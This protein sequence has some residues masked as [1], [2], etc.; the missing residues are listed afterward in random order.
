MMKILLVNKYF[1]PR[2]GSERVMFDTAR[3]LESHGHSVRFFSMTHPENLPHPD[4]A[5]F[6]PF[7]DLRER[8][9]LP[10]R[11]KT[12][13][14]ILYYRE[15]ARRIARLLDEV[16]PDIVHLH[17][18]HHQISP[19]IITPIR[20]RRIPTVMT[21]HDYKMVCGTYRL[22]REGKICE[23]C[24]GRRYSRCLLNRCQGGSLP[25]SALTAAEMFLHHRLLRLWPRIDLFIS[26]SRF[27]KEKLEEKG[28]PGKIDVLPNFVDPGAFVSPGRP[29]WENHPLVAAGFSLRDDGHGKQSGTHPIGSTQAKA[30]GYQQKEPDLFLYL[31]RLSPEKGLFTLLKA[32]ARLPARLRILGD[33]P[34]RDRLETEAA[35]LGHGKVAFLGHRP[36]EEVARELA[37]AAAVIVPRVGLRSA[38]RADR[39]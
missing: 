17:T 21:L 13:G 6:V 5:H 30:C 27:L 8:A 20:R 31:G 10:E 29:P 22:E 37:S 25:L 39:G 18:V 38:V 15:A 33:G 36:R 35:K 28:F 7:V 26:P 16:R 12:A 24:S 14:R 4:S 2:G 34:L 11:F 1:Y 23:E 32:F 3:L 19:S 9:S